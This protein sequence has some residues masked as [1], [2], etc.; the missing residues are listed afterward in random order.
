M[1]QFY[2]PVSEEELLRQYGG[3]YGGQQYGHHGH[4][5]HGHH[6]GHHHHGHHHGHHH[7][8]HHHHGH[9]HFYPYPISWGYGYPSGGFGGYGGWGNPSPE[10]NWGYGPGY[11]GQWQY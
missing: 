3:W 5:H 8:G 4:H 2:N 6:H 7:H 11:W 1:D 9:H 10:Y